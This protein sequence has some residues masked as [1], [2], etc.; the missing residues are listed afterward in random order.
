[1]TD[2]T[3]TVL[4]TAVVQWLSELPPEDRASLLTEITTTER[5]S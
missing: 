1:M 2:P 3:D 5:N 4:R